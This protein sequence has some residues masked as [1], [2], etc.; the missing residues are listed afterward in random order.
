[1]VRTWRGRPACSWSLRARSNP[2]CSERAIRDVVGEAEPLR[3][4][5]FEVDGQVFQKVVDDPEFDVPCHD[6]SDSPDPVREAYQ[7]ATTIQ[8]TRC[9]GPARC[10][11]LQFFGR[12]QTSFISSSAFT[13]SSPTGSVQCSSPIGSQRC[14]PRSP[15][16]NLF[17]LRFSAHCRSWSTGRWH[18]TSPPIMDRTSL[19]GEE[20]FPRKVDRRKPPAGAIRTRPPRPSS[21]TRRWWRESSSSPRRWVFVAPR[22]SSR[23]AR[24]WCGDGVA[25]GSEVALDFPVSRRTSP[26]LKTSAGMLAGIV[27]LV[28]RFSPDS[29]VSSFCEQVATRIREILRHQR[30]PVQALESRPRGGRRQTG[31]VS[32]NYFPSTAIQPFGS[33]PA[34]ALYT[35]FGGVEHF[36]LYFIPDG[37]RLFLSTAGVGQ[38]LSDFDVP[39]LANRLSSC[40]WP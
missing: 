13:I 3:A 35:N 32:V 33:A 23:R 8:R 38:P 27:P 36:G 5:F 28:L 2:I 25:A 18:T 14:I 24:F 15:L 12:G 4:A 21:W 1:M 11:G 39:A 40:W 17:R 22:L 16:E 30:F 29:A 20:T 7:L 34:S 6:L 9:R 10:S 31:R 19:I 26:Q 37:G